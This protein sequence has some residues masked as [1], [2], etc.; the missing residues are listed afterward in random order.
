MVCW[1]LAVV[2]NKHPKIDPVTVGVQHLSISRLDLL[3]I[4]LNLLIVPVDLLAA[5]PVLQEPT[6]TMPLPF[7]PTIVW[8]WHLP[9]NKSATI[10]RT[11]LVS[12]SASCRF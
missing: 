8:Y 5:V 10:L 11:Y 3:T 6:T 1:W 7:A 2:P 9:R 4:Q 12:E